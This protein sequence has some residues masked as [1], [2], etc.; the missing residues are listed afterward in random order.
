MVTA[1]EFRRMQLRV[2]RIVAAEAVPGTDRLLKVTVDLG[3]EQRTVVGGVAQSYRPA[4]L[5]GLQV[6]VVANLVP[7]RIR[8]VESQGMMLGVG[9]EDPREIALLTVT[10]PVPDGAR[11][12]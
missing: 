6:I 4:E 2:G 8:G 12:V 1:E 11:V 3:D 10:R 9:C 5:E 7:A